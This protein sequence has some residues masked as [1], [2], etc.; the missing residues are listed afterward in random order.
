MF[1]RLENDFQG[2]KS[3]RKMVGTQSRHL[4]EGL[5]KTGK[6]SFKC[7]GGAIKHANYDTIVVNEDFIIKPVDGFSDPQMLRQ[8]LVTEKPDCVF[9]FTDPRFFEWLLAMEDEIHQI[10]NILWWNIWDCDPSPK[11]NF[12]IYRSADWLN[13]ISY[14]TYELL[15]E[16]VPERINFVPHA[17]PQNIFFPLPED[18]KL[19]YKKQLLGKDRMD[20]L[21]AIW[22]NRN[23]KR[24][25]PN[26][27]M[28]SWKLFLDKLERKHGHRKATLICH[29]EPLD[30]EGPNL[31]QTVEY[32]N[33]QENVFFSRDHLEFEKMNVLHNI[34]DFCVQISMNEGWGLSLTEA[35]QVGNPIVAVKTGGMTRQVIDHETGEEN[36]IALP[37]EFET[38]VGSQT[39]PFIKEQYCSVETISDAFIK[40]Y[41][42]GPEKRREV[43]QKCRKY[44]LKN[45]NHDDVVKKWDE[46]FEREIKKFREN[47]KSWEML[48]LK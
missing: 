8:L 6:Y 37:V 38:L 18:Q 13:C 48:E 10:S 21:V 5:I 41:E 32:F 29:S 9:L 19:M 15:N 44:C 28:W 31:F 46:T 39:V 33:I 43:G 16:I 11:F 4:I 26:D 22:I 40:M 24:K 42:L 3:N 34:S 12:W 30:G 25:R 23:A 14:L 20:H 27:L 7:I 2:H 17:L 1:A 47:Y 36:G 45:F 35:L